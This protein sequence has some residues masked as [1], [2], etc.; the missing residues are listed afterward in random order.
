MF[1]AVVAPGIT[2]VYKSFE[3]VRRVSQLYPYPKFRKFA[4]EEQAYNF[5]NRYKMS[6]SFSSLTKYGDIFNIYV[7]LEYFISKDCIYYNFRTHGINDFRMCENYPVSYSGSLAKCKVN[8]DRELSKDRIKDHVKAISLG[9][10]MIGDMM[11]VEIIIPNYSLFY[12][13][14]SYSGT[15]SELQLFKDKLKTRVGNIAL[16]TPRRKL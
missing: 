13:I 10:N 2:G 5:I 9:L 1:Y 11:D 6:S 14:N 8:S 7:T 15:D 16:S 3:E 12:L 4:E